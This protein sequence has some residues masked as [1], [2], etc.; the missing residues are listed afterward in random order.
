MVGLEE[1]MSGAVI[2]SLAVAVPALRA[3]V[4]ARALTR[5]WVRYLH[6]SIAEDPTQRPASTEPSAGP[7][8]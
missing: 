2:G 8:G 1:M 5:E 6:D 3:R 7:R 4:R